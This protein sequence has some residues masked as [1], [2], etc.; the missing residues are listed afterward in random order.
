MTSLLFTT[1]FTLYDST[2]FATMRS[3]SV[4]YDVAY[5]LVAYLYY[6]VAYPLVAYLYYDVA[7]PVTSY[8]RVVTSYRRVV[9][10]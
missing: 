5:P 6:D 2:N 8:R 4:Y 7:Y 10:L 1:T 3:H 9:T